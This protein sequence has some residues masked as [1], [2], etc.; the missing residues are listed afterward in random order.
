M[1][2][3]LLNNWIFLMVRRVHFVQMS[4]F[5]SEALKGIILGGKSGREIFEFS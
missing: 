4:N 1:S 3:K 2:R 5:Q